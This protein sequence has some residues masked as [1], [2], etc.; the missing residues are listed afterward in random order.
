MIPRFWIA[1]ICVVVVFTICAGPA[2]CQVI[3]Q[4]SPAE[5]TVND[6]TNVFAQAMVM[7][8][9]SIPRNLLSE[10]H[11]IAIMPSMVR[12]AFVVGIQHGRGVLVVRDASG[13]WQAPRFIVITGGS[14]GY[15]I[16]VQATDLV[17]VFRTPQSVAN[18]LRGTVKIGVDASA[19]AGPVG[20]QTSA[21]TDLQL[22][23]EILSY[24]RARGAFVGV[25][26]DGSSISL[27]PT[28]E[29][30]YYQ[31]PGAVPA[32]AMNLLQTIT[33]YT[34]AIPIGVAGAPPAPAA[35]G[36][37]VPQGASEMETARQ[38]LDAASRQLVANLDENWA[39]YLALPAEVYM[40]GRV[41]TAQ[42]IQPA[43]ARY[44]DVARRSEY[45]ALHARPEFQ[46]ALNS[47][48][49]LSEVRTA[50]NSTLS[51]PPPPGAGG[52]AVPPR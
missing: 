6:A 27:D 2:S 23:A 32:S 19:A 17:L 37:W 9:N 33:A 39:R 11:A 44:E 13:A 16:G 26:I 42:A 38:E 49:R 41:P 15:Q 46:T 50:A 4:P 34:A 48:R 25:S 45:A 43:L 10:A 1:I 24:S 14:I 36:A 28:A 29:A 31:P 20:R 22:R 30:M 52:Q 7:P 5:M 40:P 51:L 12:G 18:L 47:L 8:G 21:A 35:G 3:V